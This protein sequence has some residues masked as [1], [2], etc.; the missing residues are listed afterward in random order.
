MVELEWPGQVT[1]G[2]VGAMLADRAL[3]LF[4]VL[5]PLA[6][7][8]VEVLVV[9]VA[10]ARWMFGEVHGIAMRLGLRVGRD[11]LLVA[12]AHRNASSSLKCSPNADSI[13]EGSVALIC[14]CSTCAWCSSNW[15]PHRSSSKAHFHRPCRLIR[16]F[17]CS[18]K[19]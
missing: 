7:Q 17:A 14:E 10:G 19:W 13:F 1:L 16:V 12:S 6:V 9:R 11:R 5:L 8:M 15:P 3:P 4:R 18:N 2:E